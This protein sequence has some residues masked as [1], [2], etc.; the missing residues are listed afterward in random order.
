MTTPPVSLA[1]VREQL[2]L[3]A[4]QIDKDEELWKKLL[5]ATSRLEDEVG[6]M[7]PHAQVD[8]IRSSPR[9]NLMLPEW[10]VLSVEEVRDGNDTV[11][12]GYDVEIKAGRILLS[13][14]MRA[15]YTVTYTVGRD[16]VPEALWE[17]TLVTAAHLWETQR[18][19]ILAPTLGGGPQQRP[20]R[21]FALPNRARELIVGHLAPVLG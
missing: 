12:G 9:G 3:T 2:N 4:T 19:P 5:A 21:G 7:M 13:A 15:F 14:C 20:A 16:P 8:I 18:G 11:L 17:A 10:P 6:H 1:E